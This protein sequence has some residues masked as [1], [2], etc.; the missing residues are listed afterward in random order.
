MFENKSFYHEHI[1]KAIIAFGTLFNN[2][3]VIRRDEVGVPVQDI[4]V[5]L[6]YATKNKALTR[7]NEVQDLSEG[8]ARYEIVLPRMAF[9]IISL[10]YDSSRQV[11]ATQKIVRRS[12]DNTHQKESFVSTPYNL[13]I[14]LTIYAKYQEDGLQILEQI[15]PFFHP[16]FNVT[17]N[18]LPDLSEKR[19][20]Q[21]ILNNVSYQADFV[22][23]MSDRTMV[24][25]DLNFTVKLNLYGFVDT[26]NIIRKAIANI[27]ASNDFEAGSIK[28]RRVTVNTDPDDVIPPDPYAFVVEFDDILS[29][30]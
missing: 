29:G 7:I 6:M 28:G 13:G 15:L 19:D 2:I 21:F 27:Y 17:I 5:P 3:H 11:P 1:R 23:D 26:A 30:D 9:E 22:G 14:N 10:D 18:D 12:V 25:W 24:L 8:R 4:V 20:I 16:D